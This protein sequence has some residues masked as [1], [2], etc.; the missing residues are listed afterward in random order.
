[1]S[2]YVKVPRVCMSVLSFLK[3]W[4]SSQAVRTVRRARD[5]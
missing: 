3:R 2:L 5:V 4:F 1:L